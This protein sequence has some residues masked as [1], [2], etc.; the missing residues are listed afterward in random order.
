MAKLIISVSVLVLALLILGIMKLVQVSKGTPPLTTPL[1]GP[2]GDASPPT[3]AASSPNSRPVT[4][5]T[6]PAFTGASPG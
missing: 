1:P 5:V 6:R 3:A 4:T 2:D